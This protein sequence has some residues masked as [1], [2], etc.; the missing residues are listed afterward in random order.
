MLTAVVSKAQALF[1]SPMEFLSSVLDWRGC[2][3]G[4]SRKQYSPMCQMIVGTP[5]CRLEHLE[6]S[7]CWAFQGTLCPRLSREQH[8]KANFKGGF[9]AERR[10]IE[11]HL[12]GCD[13]FPFI[14]YATVPHTWKCHRDILHIGVHRRF[15]LLQ[16]KPSSVSEFLKG[17]I[18]ELNKI[19]RNTIKIGTA[20]VR[21]SLH[22]V[23]CDTTA[24]A[25][26]RQVK[27]PTGHFVCDHCVQR[28]LYWDGQL[29]FPYIRCKIHDENSFRILWHRRNHDGP[30]P[31]DKATTLPLTLHMLWFICQR[32]HYVTVLWTA[33]CSPYESVMRLLKFGSS[34]ATFANFLSWIMYQLMPLMM[35]WVGH[36]GVV[37][38]AKLNSLSETW[39]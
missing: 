32:M 1:W 23:V 22:S 33:F 24:R 20:S 27:G 34:I 28:R 9:T 21:C 14:K 19:L 18:P 2:N 10:I 35:I 7:H 17:C 4:K 15:L 11:A 38:A 30:S 31:T 25:F 16:S 5:G 13:G 36:A 12:W 6:K 8:T 3:K 39:R 29:T 26:I 37:V